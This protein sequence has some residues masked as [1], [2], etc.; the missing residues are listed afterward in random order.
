MTELA[1]IL[2]NLPD[3]LR[4]GIQRAQ[5]ALFAMPDHL[6]GDCFPLD[7]SFAPGVY[8]RTITL[9]KDS[10]IIGK[11]HRHAHHNFIQR[12]KVSLLTEEGPQTLEGPCHF[13][14]FPGTKRIVYAHEETVWTTIHPTN[15]TDLAVIEDEVIAPNYE[16][17]GMVSPKTQQNQ[18]LR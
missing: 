10:V 12:G 2:K 15:S 18:V 4:E 11:L 14:S 6:E 9:P 17:I 1:T 13:V 3:D 7:H 8:A 16:A 5:D